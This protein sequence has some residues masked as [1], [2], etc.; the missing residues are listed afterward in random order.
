MERKKI[1]ISFDVEADGPS[2][3]INNCLQIAFVACR[4]HEKPDPENKSEWL[5]DTLDLC[6]LPQVRKSPDE[7]TMRDFWSKY[8]DILQKILE[9]GKSASTQMRALSDWLIGL[10]KEYEID[11]WVA[12]PAAY[13]WQWLNSIYYF[14][15]FSNDNRYNLPFKAECISTIQATL[16][17]FNCYDLAM[18]DY[19]CGKNKLP[20][21]HYALDDA[22]EQAFLYLCLRKFIS[23][24]K[25]PDPRK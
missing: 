2:P 15:T 22:I 6:L 9:N 3:A 17:Y 7:A 14:Y 4:Y 16:K 20:H 8:P 18:L 25:I 19:N 13:D 1:F 5:I 23:E 24:N 21:T 12:K 10:E 11:K